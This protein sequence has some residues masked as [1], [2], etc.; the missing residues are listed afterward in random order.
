[1]SEEVWKQ[2]VSFVVKNF[3]RK[4]RSISFF[5]GEP[6]L[7]RDMFIKYARYASSEGIESF[8]VTTNGT[9]FDKELHDFFLAQGIELI[10]SFDGSD[11]I[12]NRG[13]NSDLGSVLPLLRE[14]YSLV[15]LTNRIPSH[16]LSNVVTIWEAGFDHIFDNV[17]KGRYTFSDEEYKQFESQ[18]EK[19]IDLMLASASSEGPRLYLYSALAI[20][21]KF[22][23]HSLQ[24]TENC[25]WF[26]DALG[27]DVSGRIYPCHRAMELGPEYS[28]G[29]V[30]SG[31]DP[32]REASV[33]ALPAARQELINYCP[34]KY[35]QDNGCSIKATKCE[36]HYSREIGIKIAVVQRNMARLAPLIN[37]LSRSK[38]YPRV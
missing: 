12:A 23:N 22:L 28:I 19:A 8:S 14:V 24:R 4:S 3:P 32:S 29:D 13:R 17:L 20:A 15:L 7:R 31:V 18:Y 10:L 37:Q 25:G 6:L 35:V 26:S 38:A 21:Q 34:I 9:S 1:M 2:T 36:S 16:L 30:F 5:G 11:Q 27:V 33:R